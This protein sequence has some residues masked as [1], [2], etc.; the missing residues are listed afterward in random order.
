MMLL[1]TRQL[2]AFIQ[3]TLLETL[4]NKLLYAIL[5][6]GAATIG[7]T[8]AFGALSLHQDERV[9]NN[10]V[11]FANVIFLACL[12]IYQ[13]VG[14]IQKEIETRTIY[15]VLSKP[16]MRGTFLVGKFVA[17]LVMITLCLLLLFAMTIGIATFLDYA[18]TAQL[19]AAYYG[20]FLQLAIITAA[21][22][23]FS[24]FST[25]LLSALFTFSV[26]LVGNLTPQLHEAGAAFA[27]TGNPVRHVIDVVLMIV[28]DLEKLN[29]SFE[30]THALPVPMSYLLTA[31]GYAA[32]YVAFL[33][34]GAYIVFRKRDFY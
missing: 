2:G 17:S 7:A 33:L 20:L 27:K 1:I 14:S 25:T 29:L 16:V 10:L 13:G 21:A 19:F 3:N 6:F 9:F 34:G 23:F 8:S 22:I 32:V 4:R 28:P 26:F 31:T 12:A 11:L 15:T 30:L 24:S 5:F 18:I